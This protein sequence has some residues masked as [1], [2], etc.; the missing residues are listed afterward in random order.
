MNLLRHLLAHLTS[1]AYRDLAE[2]NRRQQRDL[3]R[4]MDEMY[5]LHARNM[6]LESGRD[7]GTGRRLGW[8]IEMN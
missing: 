6:I 5:R 1:P 2:Q 3:A 4:T 8:M 7:P